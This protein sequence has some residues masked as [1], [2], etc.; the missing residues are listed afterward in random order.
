MTNYFSGFGYI[1]VANGEFNQ[2]ELAT[3]NLQGTVLAR[4]SYMQP[5]HQLSFEFL[6]SLI[7]KQFEETPKIKVIGIGIPGMVVHGEVLYCDMEELEHLNLRD[8]LQTKYH[9]KVFIDNEMHFKTFG[10]FQAHSDIGL[11]DYA[12]LN[13]PEHYTY[14]AGF[15]VNGHLIRG[16]ANFSGEINF[17]PYVSSRKELIEQMCRRQH[18]CGSDFKSHHYHYYHYGSPLYHPLRL[19]FYQ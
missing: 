16:N 15:M 8:L 2:I 10:Y 14:G 1:L 4:E 9:V 19:P 18:I 7:A 5:L 6:D 12:L 17:L 3:V 13:V 11:K